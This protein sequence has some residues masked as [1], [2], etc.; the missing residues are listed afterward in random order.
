MSDS[1]KN[2]DL[3]VSLISISKDSPH[4]LRKS[5]SNKRVSI[6]FDPNRSIVAAGVSEKLLNQ[7][8]LED[9]K[10]YI[11]EI[12][13]AYESATIESKE[14]LEK[15]EELK[16]NFAK[17]TD[18]YEKEEQRLKHCISESDYARVKLTEE[19]KSLRKHLSIKDQDDN[20]V[21]EKLNETLE[22]YDELKNEME[23]I[24]EENVKLKESVILLNCCEEKLSEYSEIVKVLVQDKEI[25][26]I[27]LSGLQTEL[28]KCLLNNTS[29]VDDYVNLYLSN[30]TI[31]QLNKKN[32]NLL[33]EINKL[34][35]D[36]EVHDDIVNQ[37]KNT[38]SNLEIDLKYFQDQVV[39]QVKLIEK[40]Q[41]DFKILTNEK[42]YLNEAVVLLSEELKDIFNLF[43]VTEDEFRNKIQYIESFYKEK[44]HEMETIRYNENEELLRKHNELIQMI[45]KRNQQKIEEMTSKEEK[46]ISAMKQ[47]FN[48]QL[49]IVTIAATSRSE[50][51]IKELKDQVHA[52]E[53]RIK[54]LIKENTKISFERTALSDELEQAKIVYTSSLKEKCE[55]YRDLEEALGYATEEINKQNA[56]IESLNSK[57]EEYVITLKNSYEEE[58]SRLIEQNGKLEN[59]FT[60]KY[61]LCN[62]LQSELD[63]KYQEIESLKKQ[64]TD[65]LQQSISNGYENGTIDSNSILRELAEYKRYSYELQ[66]SYN[67]L[68]SSYDSQVNI[69]NEGKVYTDFISKKLEE[70]DNLI[71]SLENQIN[72]N[73]KK[74]SKIEL[75]TMVNSS[76]NEDTDTSLECQ[77]CEKLAKDNI[78]LE[79]KVQDLSSQIKF[80]QNQ[81]NGLKI[82]ASSY[83]DKIEQLEQQIEVYEEERLENETKINEM[84][85]RIMIIDNE[86]S[87]NSKEIYI[88]Q[89]Q[90]LIANEQILSKDMKISEL[91]SKL[92]E[93]DVEKEK[94]ISENMVQNNNQSKIESSIS[95]EDYETLLM[96]SH[97]LICD[98]R[99]FIDRV[100]I[101]LESLMSRPFPTLPDV[102]YPSMINIAKAVI[103]L[104]ELIPAK[105]S[106]IKN[107]N[108][109]DTNIHSLINELND[110]IRHLED[111]LCE[112]NL[113]WESFYKVEHDCRM[114]FEDKLKAAEEQINKLTAQLLEDRGIEEAQKVIADSS[115]TV[116]PPEL[117]SSVPIGVKM[118]ISILAAKLSTK[119][120][121]NDAL[122]R[123]NKEIADTNVLLQNRIDYYEEKLASVEKEES[124]YEVFENNKYTSNRCD[125]SDD[126]GFIQSDIPAVSNT[127]SISSAISMI[128]SHN[129]SQDNQ[130]ITDE[131]NAE[132]FKN[133]ELSLIVTLEKVNESEKIE[134]EIEKNYIE[135]SLNSTCVNVSLSKNNELL[136]NLSVQTTI[137]E[138]NS[139]MLNNEIKAVFNSKI[140]ESRNILL[141]NADSNEKIENN[142]EIFLSETLNGTLINNTINEKQSIVNS[143]NIKNEDI[144]EK[145]KNGDE[146]LTTINSIDME[147]REKIE[148]KVFVEKKYLKDNSSDK[149]PVCENKERALTRDKKS[150]CNIVDNVTLTP[151]EGSNKISSKKPPVSK[152]II[153]DFGEI[154]DPLQ[155]PQIPQ[156]EENIFENVF[157]QD[158]PKKQIIVPKSRGK[159]STAVGKKKGIKKQAPENDIFTNFNLPDMIPEKDR[160][161]KKESSANFNSFR[162]R[163]AFVA[164]D[165]ICLN[166]EPSTSR[167]HSEVNTPR[168]ETPKDFVPV[169]FKKEPPKS[170]L[171][172]RALSKPKY[173]N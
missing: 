142:K 3:D 55:G 73:F 53:E 18:T 90:L 124:K 27:R 121:D 135:S 84:N 103:Q 164:P 165:K 120:L 125:S 104:I 128:D 87:N 112:N 126:K 7:P 6:Q 123:A 131:E 14:T 9:V 114:S 47:Q 23:G 20:T 156:T 101:T 129:N 119:M 64:Q 91:N 113:N 110:K 157:A 118:K 143:N 43:T 130:C 150:R 80:M 93:L 127:E 81:I 26:E 16:K 95:N 108:I 170:I 40:Q 138:K 100:Y 24:K 136:D 39:Q 8:G 133:E 58:I 117:I 89:E 162:S 158:T 30:T 106:L 19:I 148:R 134:R 62:Q 65:I 45:E 34:R 116:I 132:T 137:C 167:K 172:P 115:I 44:I 41:E 35:E 32:N 94:L 60:E 75:Q 51:K 160:V 72:D 98:L 139:E 152:K 10:L 48:E 147:K 141:I 86:K 1:S 168:S 111:K 99:D 151:G 54:E 13:N 61:S 161:I 46:R 74:E 52:Y 37:L 79:Y 96:D 67:A 173:T 25:L 169:D 85:K 92:I 109:V 5:R 149:K 77:N 11:E 49:D 50:D 56:Y 38:I 36:K 154:F 144:E 31:D 70:K 33:Q 28:E 82:Q 12:K 69:I 68:K 140:I 107:D 145:T 2:I 63:I 59:Q 71:Q 97:I 146:I 66:N 4:S 57:N 22:L 21:K 171:K 88:L 155:I 122:L 42:N 166:R 163:G 159:G 83:S 76:I 17:I 15:L 29:L 105:N 78:G 102:D 153:T